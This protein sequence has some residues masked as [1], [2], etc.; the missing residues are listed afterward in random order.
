MER[1][2]VVIQIAWELH[3]Q[4]RATAKHMG[5]KGAIAH[6]HGPI[7]CGSHKMSYFIKRATLM[8]KRVKGMPTTWGEAEARLSAYI[9]LIRMR[10]Y[11][12]MIVC[13]LCTR[14]FDKLGGITTTEGYFCY[15]CVKRLHKI[16]DETAAL[17]ERPKAD[18]LQDI[19]QTP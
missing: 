15:V 11:P 10:I 5:L 9:L 3:R 12:L 4:Y 17:R 13:S 7:D 6:D 18:I 14:E 16:A 2:S 1:Q 8:V 19:D